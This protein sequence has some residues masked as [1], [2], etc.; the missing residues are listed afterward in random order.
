[1]RSFFLAKTGNFHLASRVPADFRW[2]P[3]KSRKADHFCCVIPMMIINT[4][5]LS[6]GSSEVK[7]PTIWTDEKQRGKSEEK[8]KEE[9][10]IGAQVRE[11]QKEADACARQGRKVAKHCVFPVFC[12]SEGPNSRLTKA[13]GAEPA[14]HMRDDKLHLLWH[15][16]NFQVK[17][18]KVN[19]R[20]NTFGS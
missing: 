14:R 13:A 17:M 19:Q 1:M 11:S 10:S 12:G 3:E 6:R 2:R 9:K 18:Y 4:I 16:A 7:L 8:V 15:E 5:V 20:R